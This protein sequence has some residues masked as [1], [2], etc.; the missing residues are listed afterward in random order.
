[1]KSPLFLGGP[2]HLTMHSSGQDLFLPGRDFKHKENASS[3]L[4]VSS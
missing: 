2:V 3:E 1:M 4:A